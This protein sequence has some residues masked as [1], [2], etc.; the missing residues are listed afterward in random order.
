[1]F[2]VS[3][4]HLSV[5]VFEKYEASSGAK[6]NKQKSEILPIGIGTISD[7]EKI[8]LEFEFQIFYYSS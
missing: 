2:A 1:M 3:T 7:T 4:Y 6:I 8:N 5:I